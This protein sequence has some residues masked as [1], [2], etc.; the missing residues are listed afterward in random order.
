MKGANIDQLYTLSKEIS[1]TFQN[2]S[3]QKKEELE[4]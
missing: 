4:E 2:T 3:N 1:S